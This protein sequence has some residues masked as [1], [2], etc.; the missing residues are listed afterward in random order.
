MPVARQALCSILGFSLQQQAKPFTVMCL[1]LVRPCVASL[2]SFVAV[3]VSLQQ[4]A[5]CSPCGACGSPGLCSITTRFCCCC[6]FVF[7]LY[8]NKQNSQ[9]V[10]PVARQALCSILGFS[11]QQQAKP[12]TVM[13]LWLARPCVAF[14]VFLSNNKQSRSP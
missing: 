2:L 9:R 3:V 4:Q 12:F 1:W 6:F 11:L 14:S 7:F 10:V 13:C 5:K 8:N